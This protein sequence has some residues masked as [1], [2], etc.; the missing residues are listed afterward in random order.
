MSMLNASRNRDRCCDVCN[1][2]I[3]IPARIINLNLINT[4]NNLKEFL[5]CQLHQFG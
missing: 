4:N 2:N 1:D 3:V 5:K